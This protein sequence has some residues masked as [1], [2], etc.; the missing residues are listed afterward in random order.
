M[1]ESSVPPR[2]KIERI[3]A[4]FW[5]ETLGRENVGIHDNFFDLGGNSLLMIRL[6]SKLREVLNTELSVLDLFQYPTISS[7]ATHLGLDSDHPLSFQ[8]VQEPVDKQSGPNKSI[9]FQLVE[10]RAEKQRQAVSQRKQQINWRIA[11]ND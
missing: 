3:I 2:N 5:Q 6:Y 8:A 11:N 9:S 4:S 10:E 1:Q 7:L